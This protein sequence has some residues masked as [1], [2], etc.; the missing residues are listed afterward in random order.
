MMAMVRLNSL[1]LRI[2]SAIT[3]GFLIA[4]VGTPITSPC[5]PTTGTTGCVSYEM[6][7]QRPSDLLHNKQDSLVHFSQRFFGVALFTIALWTAILDDRQ[8]KG[9]PTTSW[10]DKL[11]NRQVD[12]IFFLEFA[13]PILVVLAMIL[14]TL[15]LMR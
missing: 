12:I 14:A 15:R 2:V 8:R 5:A 13:I 1:A 7:I 3:L 4:A 9:K 10:E 6:A 11:S